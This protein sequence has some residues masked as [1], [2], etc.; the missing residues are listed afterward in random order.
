MKKE[1]FTILRFDSLW[2]VEV[3]HTDPGKEEGRK[4]KQK[5]QQKYERTK[6]FDSCYHCDGKGGAMVEPSIA[7]Q[8]GPV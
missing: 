6:R 8:T 5:S 1:T 7:H 3:C 4:E 2:L